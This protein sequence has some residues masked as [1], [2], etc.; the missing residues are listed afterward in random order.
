MTDTP[1]KRSRKRIIRRDQMPAAKLATTK[2]PPEPKPKRKPVPAPKTPTT[3][4]SHVRADNLNASLNAFEVWR[5]YQPLALGIDKQIFQHIAKHS[6]SCSKRVVRKL[7]HR[8]C[9]DRRY[10]QAVQAGGQRFNLDGTESGAIV[11]TEQEH[12]A[13]MLG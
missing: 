10:L 1:I 2:P 13:R 3:P 5:T 12:A 8:H 6:L 11:E 7:L 9:H 4:P